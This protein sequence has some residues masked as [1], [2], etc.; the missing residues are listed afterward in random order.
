MMSFATVVDHHIATRGTTDSATEV[1]SV[2][3]EDDW[4][5]PSSRTTDMRHH[6]D[7]RLALISSRCAMAHSAREITSGS[8][9]RPSSVNSYSTRGGTSA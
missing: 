3:Y 1:E 9:V 5:M 2:I 6:R 7:V 4:R 8:S